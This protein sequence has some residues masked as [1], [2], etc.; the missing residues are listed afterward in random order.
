MQAETEVRAANDSRVFLRFEPACPQ[1]DAS[2]RQP[3]K[4][5]L[6]LHAPRAVTRHEDDQIRIASAGA[7]PFPPADA[8]LEAQ[9]RLDRDVEVFVFRPARWTDDEPG[10]AQA[11]AQTTEQSLA[12]AVPLRSVERREHRGWPIVEHV[13]VGYTETA[14]QKRGH[15]AR[16]AQVAFDEPRVAPLVPPRQAHRR[17]PAPQVQAQHRISEVVPVDDETD[18]APSQGK[19]RDRDRWKG[20][21]DLHEH[22]I[23]AAK[24]PEYS[25]QADAHAEVVDDGKQRV[26]DA[27]GLPDARPRRGEAVDGN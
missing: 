27:R 1:L 21:R 25:P 17:M 19:P 4:L 9:D 2:C 24:S 11:G 8:I 23:R 14:G 26:L 15:P 16:H 5:P 3:G 18:T 10:G 12:E 6:E 7:G 22:Q 20:W 13:R